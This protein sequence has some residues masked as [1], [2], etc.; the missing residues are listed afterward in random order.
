M[1][2]P[3]EENRNASIQWLARK[4]LAAPLATFVRPSGR[5]AHGVVSEWRSAKRHA[6]AAA[7]FSSFVLALGVALAQPQP[8]MIGG[9]EYKRGPSREA[10]R[11]AMTRALSGVDVQW[12]EWYRSGPI[13][14]PGGAKNL[15]TKS[16][17]EERYLALVSGKGAAASGAASGAAGGKA[18]DF[19]SDSALKK[20]VIQQDIGGLGGERP[21]NLADGVPQTQQR[22]QVAYLIRTITAGR[23][24]DV[25]VSV[26]SDDGLRLWLNGHV[27]VDEG[28]ERPLNPDQHQVV[29]KLKKGENVLLAKVSQG[30]GEW[31]FAMRASY[32]IDPYVEAA[33]DY[34]LDADYPDREQTFYKLVTIPTP[35]DIVAEVGGLDCLPAPDGRPILCTRRGDVYIV[36]N[37]YDMPATRA[38][39]T[40]FASGL[41]EPL[42][43]AVRPDKEAKNGWAAYIAQRSELTKLVD[44][45]G[46]D[47]ADVMRTICD[48]WS[49]SGNYHEYAFG[50]KFDRDGNAWVT[51]NLAHTDEDGTTMG[52][53]V[54]TRGWAV[55]IVPPPPAAS[56]DPTARW[57]MVKVADGLRSPDGVGMFSDG[58]MFF[59]DNQGDFVA[60]SKLSPLYMDSFHGHQA[61]LKFR[62]G[63]AHWKDEK[64]PIPE[65]TPAAVWFPYQKMGQ[66]ASDILLDTTNG[67]FGPFAGQL[68]VGDQTHATIMRVA[69]EKVTGADGREVY[70]GACFPFRRGLASG[71][72]RMAWGTDGSMFV[73]MTDRGWGSTGPKRFGLQRIVFGRRPAPFE[74]KEIHAKPDGFE[75]EFTD[76]VVPESVENINSYSVS[77]YTYEYHPQYGSSEMDTKVHTVRLAKMIDRKHVRLTIS[78]MRGGGEGEGGQ[79]AMGYVYE[80]DFRGVQAARMPVAPL[81]HDKA[82]YTLQVVPKE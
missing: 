5:N 74:V 63:W 23:E 47:R 2:S 8:I 38:K 32:S 13:A 39:W 30:A 79:K 77:S 71:V 57:T 29:L 67:L 51:L 81:L 28:A 45:D 17:I 72:H 15:D 25:P 36:S 76:V 27:L 41:Q 33:L 78:D 65:V 75:I 58:Q 69:M 20:V 60:T 73:G 34:Q 26:G 62:G 55:K 50:P 42:G 4:C 70:Q 35:S 12:G 64:K 61:S 82:Y 1:R 56:D 68:F 46:D 49:I 21:I 11:D 52:A 54:P 14:N 43:V 3:S 44:L 24:C 31:Q 48:D 22:N 6:C 53:T 10:T 16:E 40:L 7:V 59:T 66:S 37:A 9:K 18:W 19:T 80:F